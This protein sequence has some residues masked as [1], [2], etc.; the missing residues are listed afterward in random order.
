M[1]HPV[2]LSHYQIRL[3]LEARN[4][5]A[6]TAAVSPDLGL[7]TINVTFEEDGIAFPSG[8]RLSWELAT[9]I[10]FDSV[11]CFVLADGEITRIQQFSSVTNRHASLMPTSG[12]PTL[13]LAGFP[14][15]RI[16]GTEPHQDTLTKI[17]AASPVTGQVLDTTMG[18]GYTAIEAARTA[19]HVTTIELDP[20]VIAVARMN[21]WSRALFDNPKITQLTGDCEALITTFETDSFTRVIHDPPTFSLAGE[22]YSGAFYRQLFRVL[23]RGGR[24][25]HYIGDLN[26]PL[27][28]KVSRGVIKRLGDAGFRDIREHPAAFG[29]VASKWAG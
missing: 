17:R 23:R 11:G 20:A 9:R 18:L 28:S 21:P 15:H 2:I 1:S 16:K 25:F 26:S 10:Q 6:V 22:L 13:L 27:G 4:K 3:L 14:M 29:V 7:T 8:E 19:A 5:G 12:A 24:L